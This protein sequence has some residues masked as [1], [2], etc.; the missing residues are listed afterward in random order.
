LSGFTFTKIFS[1]SF[2]KQ[3][4]LFIALCYVLTIAGMFDCSIFVVYETK[5]KQ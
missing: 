2:F 5:F 4:R 3:W 1:L